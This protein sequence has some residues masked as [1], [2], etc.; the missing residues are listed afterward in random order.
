[1]PNLGNIRGCFALIAITLLAGAR[2]LTAQTDS[3]S[4]TGRHPVRSEISDTTWR[5]RLAAARRLCVEK[6][7]HEAESRFDSLHREHPESAEPI[8]GLGIAARGQRRYADA[9]RRFSDAVALDSTSQEARDRLADAEWDLPRK[10]HLDAGSSGASG[11]VTSTWSASAEI[12]ATPKLSLTG[13]LAVVG[14][15]DAVRGIFVN[16]AGRANRQYVES[17]G[18]IASP[19]ESATLTAEGERWA[20]NDT[21]QSFLWLELEIKASEQLAA[22][23]MASPLATADGSPQV[24]IGLDYTLSSTRT[25]TVEFLQD[26]REAEFDARTIVRVSLA[27][28][29]SK[30]WTYE[31]GLVRDID[32]RFTAMTAIGNLT[33]YTR[34]TLGV[35]GEV[36]IRRGSSPQQS[37]NAGIVIR[38]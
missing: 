31:A 12:P 7:W 38:W 22:R 27:T 30:R 19:L 1:M 14:N 33:W 5:P 8:I 9:R 20:S 34:P 4:E 11:D 26:I 13:R 29:P 23:A 24:G 25:V 18:F 10:V 6:R 35:R 32:R 15:G 37:A 3:T 36:S 28:T 17:L 2:S 21:T 16:P